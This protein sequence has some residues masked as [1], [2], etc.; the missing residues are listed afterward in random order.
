MPFGLITDYD[1]D[2]VGRHHALRSIVRTMDL[3]PGLSFRSNDHVS[4]GAGM[5]AQYAS[6]S[7]SRAVFTGTGNDAL[8]KVSGTDWSYGDNLGLLLELNERVRAGVG[9]RSKV[10]QTPRR[11]PRSPKRCTP[12]SSPRCSTSSASP[13][14]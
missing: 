13:S 7:L 8:A 6:V 12:T 9:F 2:W 4:V 1:R 10:K 11:R 5:S 3:N 14:A